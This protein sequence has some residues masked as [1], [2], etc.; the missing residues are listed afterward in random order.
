LDYVKQ[1]ERLCA[2]ETLGPHPTHDFSRNVRLARLLAEAFGD[3]ALVTA[4][5]LS[6]GFS[7][8]L[9][10]RSL[11][12][13]A[14]K[15][16][17]EVLA[18]SPALRGHAPRPSTHER[19][20]FLR[21]YSTLQRVADD[22]GDGDGAGLAR[23][24]EWSST[25]HRDP[26]ALPDRQAREQALALTP[27]EDIVIAAHEA[28]CWGLWQEHNL[29]EDLL[30]L[31]DRRSR[32]D[33]ALG[34]VRAAH[35]STG[36]GEAVIEALRSGTDDPRLRGAFERAVWE[37][38]HVASVDARLKF[39]RS[40][41]TSESEVRKHVGA[42][43][44]VVLRCDDVGQCYLT[45]G[46]LHAVFEYR[47]KGMR[48]YI[49]RP[50]A[51]G[52]A[53]I[54][55]DVLV[56]LDRREPTRERTREW[57][58]ALKVIPSAHFEAR[59]CF[60]RKLSPA[61]S[62][63][64]GE[65]TRQGPL[66]TVF[67]ASGEGIRLPHGATVL[68][69]ACAIYAE[70]VV[71][72]RG[73][74]VNYDHEVDLFQPLEHGD[75]VEVLTGEEPRP[76]PNGWEQRVP[77]STVA[78]LREAQNKALARSASAA[79]REWLVRTLRARGV[80]GVID[81]ALLDLLLE[82][83]AV[84]E[85]D[86]DEPKPVHWWLRAL[87]AARVTAE[88][89]QAVEAPGATQARAD[90]LV[91]TILQRIRQLCA[92]DHTVEGDPTHPRRLLPSRVRYCERCAPSP[93]DVLV[94]R[95]DGDAIQLHREHTACSEG[96][97]PI[98]LRRTLR[99]SR[100]FVAETTNRPGL[101]SDVLDVFRQRGVDIVEVI[102]QRWGPD[103]GVFRVEADRLGRAA[104]EKLAQEVAQVP[105]VI[106]AAVFDRAAVPTIEWNLPPRRESLL[107]LVPRPAPYMCGPVIE[108]DRHFYGRR[109]ELMTLQALMST[110]PADMLRAGKT[111]FVCGPLKYGKTSL[112]RRFV[113]DLERQQHR[114]VVVA[115][116]IF[117]PGSTFSK[118]ADTL[119]LRLSE[120]LR[121]TCR[122][123]GH[124]V[125]VA[126]DEGLE[127]KLARIARLPWHPNVV[128]VLDEAVELFAEVGASPDEV[129]GV[130]RFW[131]TA[132]ETPNL[133]VVWVGPVAPVKRLN[134]A[135]Q[136]VIQSAQPVRLGAFTPDVIRDVLHAS[137]L[138]LAR[139]IQFDDSVVAEVMRWTGG[140][141]LQLAAVADEMWRTAE[142]ARADKVEYTTALVQRA[143]QRVLESGVGLN[144]VLPRRGQRLQR[145]LLARLALDS[146]PRDA[147]R[148][149]L[150]SLRGE[151]GEGTTEALAELSELGAVERNQHGA[152]R[153]ASELI[154][155]Y[156]REQAADG[157]WVDAPD[158]SG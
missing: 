37:W 148:P 64:G 87:G 134:E 112:V 142:R 125:P 146:S 66:I 91:E 70:M 4:A 21:V 55:T 136:D 5:L 7:Q 147:H 26:G 30:L 14:R 65:G 116:A 6:E 9:R 104:A 58:I 157:R 97:T 108:D 24:R 127:S 3:D 86:V 151:F 150:P 110:R 28:L 128:L 71:T 2:D 73:A 79:G 126:S 130:R 94:G 53:A 8:P 78:R 137:Q 57:T 16:L 129:E 68:N 76:L 88:E 33:A 54:H 43:G 121:T 23:L 145:A 49:G 61:A 75:R 17:S 117:V 72:A 143:A 92:E 102:A 18:A 118:V 124:A 59:R 47:S 32:F 115:E 81:D 19:S 155:R 123:W 1:L 144:P 31:R 106:S 80:A 10:A 39:L 119:S 154:T 131:R 12:D 45:L 103:W 122:R 95:V 152:Y 93:E 135:L 29:L 141:P 98:A 51:S 62:P 140:N 63:Q 100:Y 111:A 67:T 89:A 133:L 101:A 35:A 77:P 120:H 69:L 99:L 83:A 41:P 40:I 105:G 36:G 11:S 153:V 85:P 149:A 34:F 15:T 96:G 132:I 46:R 50:A 74:V 42:V 113:R 107:P 158:A 44:F 48:D 13:D 138:G 90:R 27:R 56:Q 109:S 38:R 156:V 60:G 114:P 20:A 22:D 82:D 84:S 139:T 25:F 52:Y